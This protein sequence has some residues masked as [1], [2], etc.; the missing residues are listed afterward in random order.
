[1]YGRFRPPEPLMTR[2]ES[3]KKKKYLI[4]NRMARKAK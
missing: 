2:A 4:R 3:S 1:M